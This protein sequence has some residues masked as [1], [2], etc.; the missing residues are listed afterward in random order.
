MKKLFFNNYDEF[1]FGVWLG[2][3]LTILT[4]IVSLIFMCADH[5]VRG[6]YLQAYNGGGFGQ[7]PGTCVMGD[8]NWGGDINVFCS[9]NP[10]TVLAMYLGLTG[11]LPEMKEI[12]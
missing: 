9:P 2:V 5:K 10:E 7:Q 12:K 11:K 1:R 8:I 4:I 3:P 6:Y